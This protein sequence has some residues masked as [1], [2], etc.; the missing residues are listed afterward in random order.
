VAIGNLANA[1]GVNLADN[2]KSSGYSNKKMKNSISQSP[3]V[4]SAPESFINI[5]EKRGVVGEC[6]KDSRK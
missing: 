3:P 1:V 2:G 6:G 4:L 5:N